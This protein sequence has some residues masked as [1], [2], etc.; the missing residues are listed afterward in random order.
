MELLNLSNQNIVEP[1]RSAEIQAA[2]SYKLIRIDE[3]C[4]MTS[5]AKSSINLWVAQG[6]F[7]KPIMLSPVIKV[8]KL[9]DI[10][11][12]IDARGAKTDDVTQN[13]KANGGMK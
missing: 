1:P 3:V 11:D 5:L 13:T 8:W 9:K 2:N 4:N 10:Q 6:K 7:V 12:W